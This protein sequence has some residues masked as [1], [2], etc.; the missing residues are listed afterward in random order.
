MNEFLMIIFVIVFPVVFCLAI[1]YI[2]KRYFPVYLDRHNTPKA[3]AER[4]ESERQFRLMHL[5]LEKKRH[6]IYKN[7]LRRAV[8]HREQG[9]LYLFKIDRERDK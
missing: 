3:R 2:S 4:M 1:Y 7:N 8:G 9:I 5:F 6:L